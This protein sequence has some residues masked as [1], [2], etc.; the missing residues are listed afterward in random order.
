MYGCQGCVVGNSVLRLQSETGYCSSLSLFCQQHS[1]SSHSL[2]LLATPQLLDIDPPLSSLASLSMLL[3]FSSLS[4]FSLSR[5]FL[6]PPPSLY[7]LH[8]SY[9]SPSLS[10]LPLVL[11]SPF[12]FSPFSLSHSLSLPPLLLQLS[13]VLN[14]QLTNLSIPTGS[15]VLCMYLD[16]NAT[17]DMTSTQPSWIAHSPSSA[18][19]S[20]C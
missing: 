2:L 1:F 8:L 5:S 17:S 11:F 4:L 19:K 18:M 12:F 14:S 10:L 9:F 13:Q 15:S 16:T 3:C 6:P 20:S 7:F